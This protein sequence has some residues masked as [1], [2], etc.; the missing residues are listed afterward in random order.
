MAEHALQEDL[1]VI[2]RTKLRS[3]R[4]HPPVDHAEQVAH[5]LKKELI[6]IGWGHEGLPHGA[7]TDA[8]LSAIE[9]SNEDGWGRRAALIVRR[10]AMDAQVGDFVWTRDTHGRYL[11]CRLTGGHRYE[12]SQDAMRVDVH[13]VRDAEWAPTPLNDLDVPGG[14]IRCFVGTRE[15]FSRIHDRGA[16]AMT[17]YLW[18]KLHGCPLPR[19]ELPP[20]EILTSYLDPYDVED[21]VYVWLQI[22]R[23]YVVLPRAR[24]RDTPAYEYT[25]LD[26]EGGVRA[27]AQIKTGATPV[28]LDAL[29]AAAVDGGTRTY[30]YATSGDYVGDRGQV[31]EVIE[32]DELLRFVRSDA[33]LLPPRVQAWFE[34]ASPRYQRA[35]H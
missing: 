3:T 17:A 14:V 18:E 32:A 35:A 30:A 7:S 5:C 26:R 23:G 24:Q 34:L 1:P 6:G 25:M 28:D 16:R 15:S 12:M 8:V 21:L 22:A 20:R 11:L 13:Q 33:A 9:A 10:F 31:T 2:W 19:L 29:A 4:P 27:I